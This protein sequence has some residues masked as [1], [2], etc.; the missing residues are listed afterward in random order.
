M[1]ANLQ[2]SIPS[3][4]IGYETEQVMWTRLNFDS[5]ATVNI[6]G[7]PA[8]AVVVGAVVQTLT[9]FNA[10]TTNNINIGFTDPTATV[11]NA[12]VAAQPIGPIGTVNLTMAPT[13][14]VGLSR[15]TTVTCAYS[16]TGGAATAGAAIVIVRFV[17]P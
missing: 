12:Y 7:L 9:A 6:G 8:G 2:T 3:Q 10:A 16:Q 13:T 1:V 17:V 14:N 4:D 11:A 15:P 5:P